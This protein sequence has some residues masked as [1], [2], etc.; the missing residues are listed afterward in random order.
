MENS[1]QNFTPRVKP[2]SYMALAILT[3]ILCCLPLGIVAIIK[4]SKVN[5]YYVMQQYDAA[6]QAS[7][8]AKK[9]S[10]I[11]IVAGVVVWIIY[12]LIYGAALF[13]SI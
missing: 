8:D 11:G 12:M 2:N 7:A 1:G 10:I 4:A 6:E 3:T 5:S 9:Y 13:A